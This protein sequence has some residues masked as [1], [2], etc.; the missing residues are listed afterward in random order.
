[1]IG[2][3]PAATTLITNVSPSTA[4]PPSGCDTMLAGC[5]TVTVIKSDSTRPAPLLTATLYSSASD[6]TMLTRLSVEPVAPSNTTPPL[7]H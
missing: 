4:L 5:A 2:S 1:M 3:V 6:G 7:L